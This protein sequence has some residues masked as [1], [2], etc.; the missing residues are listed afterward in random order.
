MARLS[1]VIFS[2]FRSP[3][4]LKLLVFPVLQFLDHAGVQEIPVALDTGR[5]CHGEKCLAHNVV[6]AYVTGDEQDEGVDAFNFSPC[7]VA[8][9]TLQ[10]AHRTSAEQVLAVV[11]VSMRHWPL[12]IRSETIQEGIRP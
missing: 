1:M 6:D 4:S 9:R 7:S 8:C 3:P 5:V 11:I 2:H 12:A 10:V